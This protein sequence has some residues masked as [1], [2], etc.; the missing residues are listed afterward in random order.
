MTPRRRSRAARLRLV[1]ALVTAGS[2]AHPAASLALPGQEGPPGTGSGHSVDDAGRGG[3]VDIDTDAFRGT[4]DDVDQA[5][6]D[7]TENVDQ[8]LGQ[9]ESARSAL[10][11]ADENVTAINEAI[12]ETRSRITE[13]EAR[14][15]AV[16]VDAYINPPIEDSLGTFTADSL[17]EATIKQ[18]ILDSKADSDAD[19][20]DELAT[21]REELEVQ[22]ADEEELEDL[23][24]EARDA[25]EEELIDLQSAQSEQA[26]FVAQVL[27]RLD[28]NLAEAE[29]LEGIDPAMAE[30]LREREGAVAEKVQAIRD[31]EA[32]RRALE[33]LQLQQ[34][35][36]EREARE[37][38][39]REAAEAPAPTGD[40]SGPSGSLSTV[41]C[42]AGGSI[43]VDSS[44]A[45]GLTSLLAAASADGISL[46]GGGYRDPSEQIA[47]REANCGTSY[48]D[49]YEAPSSSCSPPT[50][51]PG[52]S[53][54]EQG[55]AVDF[56][57][58]GSGTI[59]SRGSACF[60]W[61][62]AHGADY[63]FYNLPSEP[64]HWSNDGT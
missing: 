35:Q 64:W 44:M 48:Y 10:R 40:V 52:T 18:S 61:L 58:N 25:S 33:A 37:Q 55:L 54:H 8:E 49:I 13:L 47:L 36:A 19:V 23:A 2:L 20:L 39:E 63:G 21:A 9:L 14:S 38:A 29:A 15:D 42:P 3:E 28:Q 30:R 7:L 24:Q 46:C 31:A 1:A 5:L 50:A 22:E 26:L 51:R 4:T 16:V 34:E 62:A 32:T 57:C 56:T 27:R 60:Q 59:S 6:D 41:A 12:E 53:N 11:E 43:T 17:S 45:G